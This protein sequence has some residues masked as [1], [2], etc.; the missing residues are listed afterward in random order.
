MKL[1]FRQRVFAF[2]CCSVATGCTDSGL[3]E[4]VADQAAQI[5]RLEVQLQASERAVEDAR[6]DLNKTGTQLSRTE[7]ELRLAQE[8]IRKSE[9][10]NEELSGE[11]GSLREKWDATSA[12]L[13]SAQGRLQ[14]IES[15]RKRQ[16]QFLDVVGEWQATERW[17]DDEGSSRFLFRSD[18]SGNYR[19]SIAVNPSDGYTEEEPDYQISYSRTATPGVYRLDG[20]TKPE[21]YINPKPSVRVSGVFRVSPDGQSAVLENW[22]AHDAPRKYIKASGDKGE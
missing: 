11:L 15:E 5:A 18:Q 9:K 17:E 7:Q 6:S 8:S 1:R 4:K 2:I 20:K 22:D 14:A 16:E 21:K 19:R 10:T 13:D 12:Q 3:V